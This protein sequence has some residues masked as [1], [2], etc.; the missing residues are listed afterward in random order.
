MGWFGNKNKGDK[1][2]EITSLMND[3]K[4]KQ[5]KII[6]ILQVKAQRYQQLADIAKQALMSIGQFKEDTSK[7]GNASQILSFIVN[8]EKETMKTLQSLGD[9]SE[10]NVAIAKLAE[11]HEAIVFKQ[12]EIRAKAK[13]EQLLEYNKQQENRR[14]A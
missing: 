14:A 9:D 13:E 1:K 10:L 6:Q 8:S 7:N 4:E 11:D 12:N 2:S 3:E 5:A